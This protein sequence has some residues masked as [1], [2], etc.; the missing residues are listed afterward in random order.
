M[1]TIDN[2]IGGV[3]S[4]SYV[5]LLEADTYFASVYGKPL[6]D[7]LTQ[8]AQEQ[9]LISSAQAL[10]AYLEWTGTKYALD[11]AL[12]WPRV[13]AYDRDGVAYPYTAIPQIIKV[14]QFELA[15][16]ILAN[17]GLVFEQNMIDEVK[18]G[19]IG[20]KFSNYVAETGIPKFIESMLAH[21][22]AP[23][24]IDG[25]TMKMAKLERV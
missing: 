8:T 19:T 11:Q 4:N 5:S 12:D 13:N 17:G 3:A 16:Y 14:A 9:L 7:P 25:G 24:Y 22:G 20:V 21:V 10:D 23:L 6:W 1:P 15:Y 2:T 18:V